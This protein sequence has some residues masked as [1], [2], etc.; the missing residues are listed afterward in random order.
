M[1]SKKIFEHGLFWFRRDL[2]VRDNAGFSLAL[3]SSEQVTCIFIFDCQILNELVDKKDQ[4]V[5]YIHNSLQEID[6]FLQKRGSKLVVQQG[7]PQDLVP[8]LANKLKIDALFFN[9]D[10]EP[11]AKKRDGVVQKKLKAVGT[12]CH[13]IKDQVVFAKREILNDQ[14]QPYKVFSPYK[15]KWL[16]RLTPDLIKD[17]SVTRFSFTSYNVLK[18]HIKPWRLKDIGFEAVTPFVQGGQEHAWQ[19]LKAFHKHLQGYHEHRNFPAQDNGTSGLSTC[20]RFGTV[21]IRACVRVACHGESLGNQTWLSELIWR[22]FYHMI[23]DQYPHVAS[24][25][26]KPKYKNLTWPGNRSMFK[27]WCEGKTGYPLVDAAMRCLN[28]KGWM[29]NRLRMVVSMFLTKDL[30]CNYTWGEHYFAEKLIDFD[31]AAN[32]GGWQWSA[33]TGC[34]AQP[35]FRV[36]N[37]WT[38]SKKFDGQGTFIRRYC[39]ELRDYPDKYIHE[40]FKAPKAVQEAAG[41]LIGID[42]PKPIVDHALQ[43]LKA[44]DMFK[45]EIQNN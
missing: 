4:R 2:R 37:P 19:K 32:N 24:E 20:L 34:D 5:V 13:A 6:H 3:E 8:D 22:D 31:L 7:D 25:T 10:Y 12:V 28:Q 1:G 14:G 27:K 39:K 26:F 11:Y 18:K 40:P 35:Y 9:E 21:S 23:L 29:H 45:L 44:I 15:K 42:Y 33:S 16:S 38:Q 43:R 17:R 41:C 36:F 30:L